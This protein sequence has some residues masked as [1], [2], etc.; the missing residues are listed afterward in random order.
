MG[1]GESFAALAVPSVASISAIAMAHA[2]FVSIVRPSFSQEYIRLY[3]YYRP[4]SVNS[5]RATPGEW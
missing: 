4:V 2:F 3:F 1:V 5:K